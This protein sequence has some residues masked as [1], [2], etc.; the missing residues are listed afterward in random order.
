[1]KRGEN[2]LTAREVSFRNDIAFSRVI[3]RPTCERQE[4]IYASRVHGTDAC[5][6]G[7]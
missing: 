7:Q 5:T 1:M 3:D 4:V 2:E 6:E